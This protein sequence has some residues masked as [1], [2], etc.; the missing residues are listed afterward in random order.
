LKNLNFPNKEYI[1]GYNNTDKYD[2]AL[3]N[4]PVFVTLQEFNTMVF[5]EPEL[6]ESVK[7]N[8]AIVKND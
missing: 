5:K 4:E 7:I 2:K 1:I 8:Q 6:R 3:L